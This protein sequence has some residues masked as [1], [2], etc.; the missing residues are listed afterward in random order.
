MKWRICF[1]CGR[2]TLYSE[3]KIIC[4]QSDDAKNTATYVVE[5]MSPFQVWYTK[6][7][8]NP[9]KIFGY[10]SLQNIFVPNQWIGVPVPANFELPHSKLVENLQN[11]AYL[12]TWIP[13]FS[14]RVSIRKSVH[15]IGRN[16][17]TKLEDINND[18]IIHFF[19]YMMI[20][21]MKHSTDNKLSNKSAW[22]KSKAILNNA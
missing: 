2:S 17:K 8:F 10:D 21:S 9:P 3:K 18:N 12:D 16:R 7:S 20:R 11:L 15:Q 1:L 13:S 6:I 19:T 5:K 22:G 14:T 4:C